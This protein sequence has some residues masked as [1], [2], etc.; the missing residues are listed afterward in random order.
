MNWLY[1]WIAFCVGQFSGLGIVW[2][3]FHF[4]NKDCESEKSMFEK[5]QAD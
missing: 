5:K 1:L 4:H 3:G 2:L